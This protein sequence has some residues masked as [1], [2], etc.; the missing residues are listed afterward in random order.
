MD[1]TSPSRAIEV[2]WL[3][4]SPI[5]PFIVPFKEHLTKLRYAA[6]TTADYFADIKHFAR[7]VHTRRLP[8]TRPS[9]FGGN[10]HDG[11]WL[12]VTAVKKANSIDKEKVR[13]T[14]EKTTGFVGTNGVV[15]MTPSDHMGLN[16]NALRMLEIRNGDWTLMRTPFQTKCSTLASAE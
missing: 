8:L 13:S 5:G 4:A 1:T 3:A 9:A 2:D 15:N 11:L 16:V 6:S 7:W 10:A 12:Y 14:L